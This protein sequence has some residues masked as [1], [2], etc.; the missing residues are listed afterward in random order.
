MAFHGVHMKHFI[1]AAFAFL[2]IAVS[3]QAAKANIFDFSLGDGGKLCINN[4]C[5]SQ[6][7]QT[8]FNQAKDLSPLNRERFFL[9][10]EF[11]YEN[12]DDSIAMSEE[13]IYQNIPGT[14]FL[15]PNL[16][17]LNGTGSVSYI[18]NNHAYGKEVVP[19][20]SELP[21]NDFWN[22][23]NQLKYTRLKV[24]KILDSGEVFDF[25]LYLYQ[26]ISRCAVI[27]LFINPS[28]LQTTA[29]NLQQQLRQLG[30]KVQAQGSAFIANNENY[31]LAGKFDPE[32]NC[33]TISA[34]DKKINTVVPENLK[35]LKEET[36]KYFPEERIL[37]QFV[38]FRLVDFGQI[39]TEE[40]LNHTV[41]LVTLSALGYCQTKQSSANCKD[42]IKKLET[43]PDKK[44]R[45][46]SF[47]ELCDAK[48]LAACFKK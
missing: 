33:L 11:E 35:R 4:F 34:T 3:Q 14:E 37:P 9:S 42:A 17:F 19:Y 46:A 2:L 6:Y 16:S 43:V 24:Y 30:F 23:I 44:I 29:S 41:N 10:A 12:F 28:S 25:T 36:A 7:Y 38:D 47:R 31:T 5:L 13:I 22:L 8:P 18:S 1:S 26:E 20:F 45:R 15:V 48:I 32:Y 40:E 39:E 27:K 21:A